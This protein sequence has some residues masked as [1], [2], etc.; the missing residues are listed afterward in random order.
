MQ[1]EARDTV[2]QLYRHIR[3]SCSKASQSFRADEVGRAKASM[4]NPILSI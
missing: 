4:L 1:S 3:Y 2:L